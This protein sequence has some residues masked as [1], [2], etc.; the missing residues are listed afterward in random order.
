M[1][2]TRI[3]KTC[4]YEET[5]LSFGSRNEHIERGRFGFSR[6]GAHNTPHQVSPYRFYS[7]AADSKTSQSD[8]LGCKDTEWMGAPPRRNGCCDS[9]HRIWTGTLALDSTSETKIYRLPSH[10]R[11]CTCFRFRKSDSPP[12]HFYSSLRYQPLRLAG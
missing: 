10:S 12:K 1:P 4:F 2:L 11:T 8:S 3:R 7:H 6:Q 5:N 9:P